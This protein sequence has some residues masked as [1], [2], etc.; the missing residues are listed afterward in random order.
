LTVRITKLAAVGIGCV[1][2]LTLGGCAYD[3]AQRTDRVAYHA[4]DAV[5]ANMAIQTIDPSKATQNSTAG[6][7][8]NGNVT[9]APAT[10]TE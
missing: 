2:L 1:A 3:Y 8:K 7:G 6:L 9:S 10:T 5:A 4:G